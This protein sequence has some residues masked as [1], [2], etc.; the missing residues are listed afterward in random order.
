MTFYIVAITLASA[1]ILLSKIEKQRI[2]DNDRLNRRIQRVVTMEPLTLFALLAGA[3]G[4]TIWAC[5][6][7]KEKAVQRALAEQADRQY[8]EKKAKKDAEAEAI[9]RRQELHARGYNT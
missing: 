2:A 4:P 8:R 9:F 1:G 6:Q 5:N 7:D 3:V